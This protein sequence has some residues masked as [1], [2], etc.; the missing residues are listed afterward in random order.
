MNLKT[1]AIL[2]GVYLAFGV[3]FDYLL[4]LRNCPGNCRY[5][6]TF[7]FWVAWPYYLPKSSLFEER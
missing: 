3:L 7:Q 2:A 5:Q 6:P 1:L 4:Y